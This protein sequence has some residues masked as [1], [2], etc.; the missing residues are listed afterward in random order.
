[1]IVS[2]GQFIDVGNYHFFEKD[3]ITLVYDFIA[4]ILYRPKCKDDYIELN[5]FLIQYSREKHLYSIDNYREHQ[6]FS[7]I[8]RF[9]ENKESF[10]SREYLR[11]AGL[12]SS[13]ITLMISQ[14][15]NLRCTY[16][17]GRGGE[18][19][20]KDG[21]LMSKETA[22]MAMRFFVAKAMPNEM[23]FSQVTF[24]GGEPLLNFPLI[25]HVIEFNKKNFANIS[26]VYTITT[27][28]TL[29]TQNIA[30][31]FKKEN[32]AILVSLDGFKEIH[33]KNRLFGDGGGSFN[34][35]MEGIKIL[36]ENG[37]PFSVR[38]TL[39]HEFYEKYE[40]IV[41]YFKEL[42]AQ[43]AYISRLCDYDEE[44]VDVF[45]TDVDE[46]EEEISVVNGFHDRT[47]ERIINGEN[48]YHVP[49]LTMYERIHEADKSLISCGIFKGSIT[50]SVNG[51]LYPCHRF[52]GME[53]YCFGNVEGKPDLGL[54]DAIV[55]NLDTSTL[56]CKKCWARYLC[57]RGCLRDI[58]KKGGVF[59]E[60]P[61]KYCKIM[62]E[63]IEKAL[64]MYY[65]IVTK[66]PDYVKEFSRKAIEVYNV[67]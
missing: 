2:E 28:L 61:D 46:L 53:G 59:C 38:A 64:M 62:R 35:V 40:D 51:D 20:L 22:E 66:R 58:A 8:E 19:G 10:S 14:S 52:V 11:G 67:I 4:N 37:I 63:S 43:Q 33:D 50:V 21:G 9:H 17:Y 15:C 42:G 29:M 12:F 7:F 6:Y 48:P 32:I 25:K 13:K 57:K 55:E 54:I 5:K 56:K 3:G 31:Y 23:K 65:V 44:N 18:F 60:Y 30:E 47:H 24:F 1:M 41:N 34:S 27:N 45:D 26:F 16:C 39:S 36:N 49:F